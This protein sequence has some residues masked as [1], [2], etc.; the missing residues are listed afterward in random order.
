[1]T[2]VALVIQAGAAVVLLFAGAGKLAQPAGIRQT[3]GALGLPGPP[4]VL[5]AALAVVELGA[6]AAL[7]MAPGS[8]VTAAAVLG[9]GLV[10]ALAGAAAMARPI[11]VHCACL[12]PALSGDLGLR[13]LLMLPLWAGVAAAGVAIRP[14]PFLDVRPEL[15]L[16]LV[17]AVTLAVLVQVVPLAREH[18]TLL[19]LMDGR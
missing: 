8:L 2:I 6:A 7:V 5:A 18:R 12:G 19:E 13:Q 16:A 15:L 11:R 1:M 14:E 3:I 4:A 10:F 17:V 9:L